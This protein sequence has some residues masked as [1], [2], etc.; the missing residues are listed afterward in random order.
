MIGGM[1]CFSAADGRQPTLSG[2]LYAK[3]LIGIRNS[4]DICA[5][6]KKVEAT[7]IDYV[8]PDRLHS[9]RTDAGPFCPR[10]AV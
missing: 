4:F 7:G 6:I 9:A 3:Q 5:T 8:H 1:D 10:P 2:L